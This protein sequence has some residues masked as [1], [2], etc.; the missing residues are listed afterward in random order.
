V[1]AVGA[2]VALGHISAEYRHQRFSMFAVG[3]GWLTVRDHTSPP[4][5]R[6]HAARLNVASGSSSGSL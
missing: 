3:H 5:G 2:V 4:D 6:I 1:S